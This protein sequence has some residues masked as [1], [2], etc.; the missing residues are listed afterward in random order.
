M[1]TITV[2]L[3]KVL[4]NSK[5]PRCGFYM[6]T[7]EFVDWALTKNLRNRHLIKPHLK[8]YSGDMSKGYWRAT[9]QGIGFNIKGMLMDGQH[10][11]LANKS[12]G[13]PSIPLL[14]CFGLEEEAR[15]NVD[16]GK[17][18]TIGDIVRLERG[19]A[20]S[21]VK[22][23]INGWIVKIETEDLSIKK[24]S[25]DECLDA[26]DEYQQSIDSLW[27]TPAVP[28]FSSPFWAPLVYLHHHGVPLEKLISFRD[29]C[30]TGENLGSGDPRLTWRRKC[31]NLGR[32]GAFS[33]TLLHHTMAAVCKFLQGKTLA[34]LPDCL[35]GAE[36][37]REQLSKM[38]QLAAKNTTAQM[39]IGDTQ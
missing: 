35:V 3:A 32:S 29:G 18:R 12:A 19:T 36:Q 1:E 4:L 28:G 25:P 17:G 2:E 38:K 11:L 14:I 5:E 16:Q 27:K 39:K 30:F 9:C 6:T 37:V 22:A 34:R 20:D 13:Y 10:R 7:K 26:F 31:L 21:N 33:H 15:R 23:A 24:F 8:R